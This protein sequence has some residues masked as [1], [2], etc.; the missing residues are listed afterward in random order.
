MG[1]HSICFYQTLE[2]IYIFTMETHFYII[3][4]GFNGGKLLQAC[5]CEV[6]KKTKKK[7]EDKKKKCKEKK[8]E[9]KEKKNE[10][11]KDK[12]KN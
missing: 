6:K 7:K 9:K 2:Y 8:R 5:F 1:I 3:K 10:K 11:K 12:K 4:V